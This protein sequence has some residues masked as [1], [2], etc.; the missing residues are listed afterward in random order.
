MP[1]KEALR[2]YDKKTYLKKALFKITQNKFA[3]MLYNHEQYNIHDANHYLTN[4]KLP[5]F[6]NSN[7][8]LT[9]GRVIFL[10][11]MLLPF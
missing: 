6:K 7:L 10:K 1:A 4:Q 9:N 11:S 2:A 5:N 3:T 8:Y